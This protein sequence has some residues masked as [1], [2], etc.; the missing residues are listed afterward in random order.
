M[1]LVKWN[2]GLFPVISWAD[3]LFERRENLLKPIG[4]G[5]LVPAVNVSETDASF[6]LEL[7]APGKAKE[8][9][10]VEI[11]NGTLTISS[12]S[13]E[14]SE[15]ENKNYTRKEYSYSAFSRSFKLPENVNEEA[16]DAMYTD[17]V[18]MV[19]LPKMELAESEKKKI[20]VA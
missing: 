10:N 1:S 14:S 9:F 19:T 13:E 18:L 5:A 17:G 2:D 8:D 3:D 15:S 20:C 4:K 16:I 12:K 7:A 6:Q 11:E